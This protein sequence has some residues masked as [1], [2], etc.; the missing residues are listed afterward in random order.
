M[1]KPRVVLVGWRLGGELERVIRQGRDR[2]DY[3]VV[4]MDLDESLRPL[5]DWRQMPRP[6][7]WVLP[8]RLG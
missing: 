3:T 2:F 8:A 5:V 4:S 6:R 1:S 7:L